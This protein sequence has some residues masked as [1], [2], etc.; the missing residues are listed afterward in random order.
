[1]EERSKELQIK[2]EK[3]EAALAGIRNLPLIPKV[4]FNVTKLLSDPS[5]STNVLAREIGKDLGLTT[6]VLSIANSPM[7]G[8]QRKVTSLEFAIIVLGFKE[9][10]DI[11]TAV[12]LADAIKVTNDKFFDQNEFWIHSLVIGTAAKNISQNLGHYDIGSDAFVAGVLH[13]IGIQ[14]LYKFFNAQFKSIVTLVRTKN[15][16][17]ENAE[18]EV[19]GLTHQEIGQFLSNKW[20]LPDVLGDVMHFHHKPI[21]ST[22]NKV[23]SSII[24]LADYMTQKFQIGGFY[25]DENIQLDEE[26]NKVLGFHSVAELDTFTQNY[27][28]LYLQT[29]T[30]IKF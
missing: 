2:K 29:A 22:N 25:W 30:S 15:Y 8:L 5:V 21:L 12:S 17:F 3:T 20:N 4:V 23:V 13:D 24:H 6:K 10:S 14:I 9:M 1:M 11:V 18:N 27:K 16:S 7:Y 28:D 26:I 19:L